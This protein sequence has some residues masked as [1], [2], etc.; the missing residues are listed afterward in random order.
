MK[1]LSWQKITSGA[2]IIGLLMFLLPTSTYASFSYSISVTTNHTKVP[3]DQTNF[4]VLATSTI[5]TM[6]TV[7]NGGHVQNANGYDIYCYSDSVLTTRIPCEREKY[8]ATT[9]ELIMWVKFATLSSSVDNVVYYGYGDAS[10]S[11][12][13]NLDATFGAT[14]VWPTTCKAV[15][16]QPDGSTLSLLDSTSNANG[17]TN[18]GLTAGVGQIDGGS[19][20]NGSSNASKTS[21][22]SLNIT[23]N[24]T[25]SSWVKFSATNSNDPIIAKWGTDNSY[26]LLIFNNAP[27]LYLNISGTGTVFA[28]SATTLNDGN[29]HFIQ[30]VYNSANVLIY[31]DGVLNTT[32]GA[33][34]GTIST[35]NDTGTIGSYSNG[36]GFF[37]GSIDESRICATSQS[38]DWFTTEYNNQS[39]VGTFLTFGSETP[40]VTVTQATSQSV[41]VG[42]QTLI[43]GGQ[44]VIF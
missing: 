41:F 44:T 36:S 6:K 29:W 8:V 22:A 10:I 1:K 2:I 14:S 26:V 17:L 21:N 15:W 28:Q 27:G 40:I 3:S 7:G 19:V 20:L 5:A 31:I 43:L 16:H 12:D 11:T 25:V 33:T 35:G 13:P 32:G 18:S 39:N 24:I 9:G 34:S 4:P 42:G 23:G 37:T 30:G 38:A